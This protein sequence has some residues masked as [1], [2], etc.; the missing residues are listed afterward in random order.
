MTYGF[1]MLILNISVTLSDKRRL[2]KY[3]LHKY[4][5]LKHLGNSE[6]D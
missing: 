5:S 3:L 6:T 1:W 4:L 2:Q